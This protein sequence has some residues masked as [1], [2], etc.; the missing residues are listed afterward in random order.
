MNNL[1][2]YFIQHKVTSWLVTLLLGIGGSIAFLELG[3]LEDPMFT[4][5]TAVVTAQ[6]PGAS[7]QQVEEEVTYP[8]EN[9]IQQ[10]PYIDKIRSIS[11]NGMTQITVDIQNNYGPDDLPQIW[12]ELR[13]KV[14]DLAPSLPPGV[15]APVVN[16]DF[17]DV[18]G[19]WLNISG[20]GY[21]Y[22]ELRDFADLLRRE[23]VLVPGVG[24]VNLNG[25]LQEQV[26]IEMSR[27]KMT[28]LGISPEQVFS[29]LQSQN[30]VSNAGSIRVGSEYIRLHPTGEFQ[31]VSELERLLISQPGATK[32]IYLS[33]IANIKRGFSEV[34]TNLYRSNGQ[35]AL[36]LGV[37][38]AP[39][40]NVVDAGQ[41]VLARLAELDEARPAGMTIDTFYNQSL[42]V[43]ASVQSFVLNFIA[44]V[45]IVVGILLIFMGLRSGL[46]IGLI[47]ALTVLGS[48]IFMKLWG[49][50]LQRISLGAL[51]IA[52]GMLVD[53]AIVV[54]E[55]VLVGLQRGQSKLEA[56]NGIV[57]QTAM[58]LL[59]ATVIAVLAFAPIGLSSDSTGEYCYS[60]F[61]VLLISLMLS[62]VTAITI[63]PFFCSLMFKEQ[64]ANGESTDSDPYK[65]I[66]FALYRRLLDFCMHF[67]VVTLVV[68]GAML[69]VAIGGFGQVRQSFFPPSNTPMFFID[70]W[71][72]QGTDIRDTEAAVIAAEK[73]IHE[74]ERV[75]RTVS[76]IGRGA[77][78]FILTYDPEKSYANYAQILVRANTAEDIIP[79]INQLD[80]AL[81]ETLPNINIKFRQ[82]MLGPGGGAKIE[83]R[84]NGPDPDVLR[85]L[86]QQAEHI[87]L[88][89]LVSTGVMHDWRNRSKVIR[90]QLDEAQSRATGVN[91]SDLDSAL[92]T[93]FSGMQVGLYRDGTRMLPI[94]AR[95]PS[96]ERLDASQMNNLQ[97]WSQALSAYI[98]VSQVVSSFETEWENALIMRRNRHRTL[99]VM[100]DPS[101]ISGETAPQMM[102]R[103]QHQIEDIQLPTGYTLEWGGE[104]ENSQKA[105][106]A[107]FGALPL[108]FL[109]MFIITVLLFDSFKQASVIW[110]T[111]PLAMIGVTAGFLMTGI[112]FGFMALLG[113][114]SLSGMLIK[115]GIVLVDEINLQL[116]SGKDAYECVVDAAVSRV[117]PVSMAALTTILGMAPLLG[118]AFFQSM[119]VVIM[120]GLAAATLLTLVVVPVLF[121]L[122][123]GIKPQ[124]KA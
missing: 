63:T 20:T 59:G 41:A 96:D 18:F 31:H 34:P 98:P 9:A 11:S 51:V 74:D 120:F 73:L 115:N 122:F 111:V 81:P 65:G 66:I 33:D 19:I 37:S 44:S 77:M 107:V 86:G 104:L 95:P 58:P 4:I 87:L 94:I 106:T 123:F 82:L 60:L 89:D 56:A 29:I 22:Q 92:L 6:Y 114:L 1:A 124:L 27:T 102:A 103:V 54:V 17:G 93:N 110:I 3:R 85:K 42:E 25:T 28:A 64:I 24:K 5:K 88:A 49:I 108:G 101:I 8:L 55:G 76:T 50:E 116:A 75:E 112:P 80:K 52:L 47:L 38:F 32:L 53:N 26:Q 14:N 57:K 35:S 121:T 46:L 79:L 84:F 36:A 10:L 117:R 43:D 97:V 119:A 21:S 99:T 100:A 113:I 78:R 13:R 67:R 2:G 15:K 91:K 12:D 105:Q 23:L 72:P 45:V 71:L 109:V 40:V 83:A 16:D 30:V 62:W 68:L 48:F 69:V 118:D 39:K 7:P 90:P 70:V 61:Q